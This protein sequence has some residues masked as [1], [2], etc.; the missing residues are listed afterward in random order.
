MQ[1]NNTIEMVFLN[2]YFTVATGTSISCFLITYYF[3]KIKQLLDDSLLKKLRN[4]NGYQVISHRLKYQR[5]SSQ[6]KFSYYKCDKKKLKK[7]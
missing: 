6:N 2:N 4:R 3:H 7:V 5:F 1:R